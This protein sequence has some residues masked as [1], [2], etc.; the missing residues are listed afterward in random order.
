MWKKW[1]GM[2]ET[3]TMTGT[4]GEAGKT[5]GRNKLIVY[6][7][8]L[9]AALAGLLFGLDIG[10]IS[11]VLP[12]LERPNVW[13]I[14][15]GMAQEIV[16]SLLLGA[17]IGTVLSGFISRKFGRRNAILIS[18]V[19][20]AAGSVLAAFSS[21]PYMLIGIRFVLGI[22]VG[23]ASFTAP[24]YLSEMA[25]E[26]IRGALVSMYQLMITVGIVL[27]F[28]SDTVFSYYHN[29]RGMVGIVAVPASFM[30]AGVL[31]LPRSPRWLVLVNRREE[32][33]RVLGRLR[34]TH[35][36][37]K[38][39]LREIE[40]NL[41]LRKA[42]GSLLINR[43]F[44]KVLFLGAT[45]QIFQQFTGINV[46]MYYAPRIFRDAGMMSTAQ[47]MWG[48]VFVGLVNVFA[49]F[50]AIAFVDRF[51]RKPILYIGYIVMGSSML[52]LGLM[53]HTGRIAV[54]PTVQYTAI[55]A[56]FI[57]IAGF[58]MSAGPVIWVIC[59]EVYPLAGRDIGITVSTATNWL[60]NAIVGAT[61]LTML[62]A[63]G[64][65]ITFWIFTS[66]NF[67]FLAILWFFVPET[68]GISLEKI[69]KN[70]FSGGRKLREI[71]R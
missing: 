69:E 66:I 60:C 12:E 51:G 64:D 3:D 55:A 14:D 1:I 24:L 22:A 70:L 30:F 45:L 34:G 50:I 43:S 71:G 42:G 26:N 38:E 68:K 65:D 2:N 23:I 49:T 6:F 44:L 53:F 11:G 28:I 63:L 32:A 35:E 27:A 58:A 62:K 4:V 37:V 21:G 9:I 56:L 57:F 46:V 16:S 20:F 41:E 8:G 47:Q 40:K 18:A 5:T 7:A 52:S 25:P 54:N 31:F 59:S 67:S 36:E 39:E 33:E 15:T 48:T 61:F 17:F 13:N 10:V 19:I 29:W